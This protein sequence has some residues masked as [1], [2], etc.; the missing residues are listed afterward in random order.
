MAKSIHFTFRVDLEAAQKFI[1]T[2]EQAGRTPSDALRRYV[3]RA[4]LVPAVDV[5]IPVEVTGG[6]AH[7]GGE[8]A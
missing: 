5:G 3:E 8:A 1:R 2:C 4:D 7:G 6:A